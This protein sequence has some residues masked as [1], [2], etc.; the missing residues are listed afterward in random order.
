MVSQ[1]VMN[2]VDTAMVGRLGNASLAAVGMASFLTFF[3]QAFLTGLSTGV[4]AMVARLKGAGQA[5][6][7]TNPLHGG[8]LLALIIGVPSSLVLFIFA[9]DIFPLVNDDPDVVQIGSQYFQIRVLAIACVGM[10]FCFRGY[11][12]A[13]NLSAIYMRTIILMHVVNISLNYILIFGH[14]GAPEMGASGAALGTAIST[15]FGTA[16]YFVLG[17]RKAGEAGF[18]RCRPTRQLIRKLLRLSVPTGVQQTFFAAGLSMLFYIVGQVGTVELAAANVLINVLLVG[19]LP[20]IALG[21]AAT[22]LV[23]QALGRG[24][25]VDA[26]QW[27]FDVLKCGIVILGVLGLPMLLVPELILRIFVQDPET[28]AAAV[29]PMRVSGLG[30]SIDSV[31]L[32]LQN[33]LLGAGDTKRT[34]AVSIGMQWI[35]FLPSAY[36]IGPVAGYG[37]LGIWLVR[38]SYRA[39]QSIIFLMMWR[40]EKWSQI[41]I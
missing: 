16:I 5:D 25:V 28:I 17:I 3:S 4:Q 41:R 30:L 14:F 35:V 34:A 15:L 36:L 11:W 22:S 33:A 37:L 27:G 6:G 40:G 31:G 9:E 8:L 21:L 10:N 26:K 1:N 23:G 7:L 18:L 12:N 38:M 20:G 29:T 19:I 2:L 39:L 24:D 13:V 32:V